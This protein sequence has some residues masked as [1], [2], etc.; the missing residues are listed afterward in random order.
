MKFHFFHF[1]KQMGSPSLSS[2]T[3]LQTADGLL[4]G[5]WWLVYF[6]CFRQH[7]AGVWQNT[8]GY[9]SQDSALLSREMS[10]PCGCSP[11][12]LARAPSRGKDT[13]RPFWR[14]CGWRSPQWRVCWCR[15]VTVGDQPD[16]AGGDHRVIQ[17]EETALGGPSRLDW[18][19]S[20]Q[21]PLRLS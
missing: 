5:D 20:S 9:F 4:I 2:R 15:L 13:H 18:F 12:S 21:K 19:N 10:I 11:S 8:V 17:R 3:V 14:S 1:L 6:L 7:Y 16:E